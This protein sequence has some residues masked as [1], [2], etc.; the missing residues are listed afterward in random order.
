MGD[1]LILADSMRSPEMRHEV[2]IAI[3]DEFLYAERNGR[4]VV[5]VSS[6]EA[7]RIGAADP[8]IEVI[9]RGIRA[10]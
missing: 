2:P 5:V 6:L 7:V 4:R 10:R 9:P 1:V 8:G 3:P